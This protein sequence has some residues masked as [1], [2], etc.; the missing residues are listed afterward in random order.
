L[1]ATIGKHGMNYMNAFALHHQTIGTKKAIEQI[2]NAKVSN[3]QLAS[4]QAIDD[5]NL[6]PAQALARGGKWSDR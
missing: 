1:I 6:T 5:S 2:E 4:T 3:T